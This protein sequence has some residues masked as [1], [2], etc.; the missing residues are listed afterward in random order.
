MST[1][2]LRALLKFHESHGKIATLTMVNIGQAKGVLDVTGDGQIRSFREKEDSDG[3]LINGGFMVFNQ[4]IF[5]Y[6]EDDRTVLEQTPF[7]RL[8]SDGE[9]MGYYHKGFW[10]CMDTQREKKKLE[11]LW[12][13]GSAPWKIWS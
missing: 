5:D 10:Q 6:L 2:D 11:E 3:T 9:L 4:G 7:K 1:V 13:S 8:S 12:E